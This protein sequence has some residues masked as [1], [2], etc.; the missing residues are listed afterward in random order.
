MRSSFGGINIGITALWAQQKSLDVTGHNISNVN[1]PGY[2]RQMVIHASTQPSTIGRSGSNQIMQ[3]GTGVGVQEIRQYRDEFLDIKLR[4]EIKEFGYW[5]ARQSSIEELETIFNDNSEEGLQTVMNNMW[6][7]WSQLSKPTGGLTARS[8]VKESAIAFI[9][10]VKNLDLMLTNFRKHKDK[11]LKENVTKVNDMASRIAEMNYKIKQVE[12]NGSRANDFRDERERLINELSKM[13]SVQVIDSDTV[14]IALEGCLLVDDTKVN[15]L[16]TMTE[17]AADGYSVVKWANTLDKLTI[18]GGSIKALIDTR[19]ELV[20]GF[21]ERLNQFVIGV[22]RE[23]NTLH[24]NG[25]GNKD[26]VQRYMFVVENNDADGINVNLSNISLHSQLIDVN[27][28][29]A[30]TSSPPGNYEDNTNALAIS[31]LRYQDF[32][33]DT[34][35]IAAPGPDRKYNSDEFYRNLISDVGIK[36]MEAKTSAES[37]AILVEQI[38][39]RRQSLMAVSLDEE[40]SNLIRFEHSYNAAARIVNAMDEMLEIIVNKVGLGGR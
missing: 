21:R 37:Q 18:S 22:S 3:M 12:S 9:D 38:E 14:N 32:F 29:A 15:K 7:S 2:S 23:I 27:N 13:A 35:Y 20:E 4:R 17:N 1:T 5:E 11:E 28:I 16:V 40:M 25:R 26:D 31:E 10:T 36:G 6:N 33:S 34:L 30:A 24:H 19:D 8:L 39:N